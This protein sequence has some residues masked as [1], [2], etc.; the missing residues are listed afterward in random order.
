MAINGRTKDEREQHKADWTQ[1]T[2]VKKVLQ[3]PVILNGDVYNYQDF[4]RA[5]SETGVDGVMTAR[6][7][8]SNPSIFSPDYV[9]THVVVKEYLD[10]ALK[11]E[12]N[13]QNTKYTILRML[14]GW[15]RKDKMYKDLMT[16]ITNCREY[17]QLQKVLEEYEHKEDYDNTKKRKL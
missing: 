3:I 16:K 7:A 14:G 1:I 4:G 13:Y 12:N 9:E 10:I 17:E 5:I 6:G 15:T 2:A 11:R 8:L